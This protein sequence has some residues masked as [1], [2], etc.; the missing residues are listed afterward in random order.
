MGAF[1]F[2]KTATSEGDEVPVEIGKHGVRTSKLLRNQHHAVATLSHK[3]HLVAVAKLAL[4]FRTKNIVSL[5]PT[6]MLNGMN[7]AGTITPKQNPYGSKVEI[8]KAD[9]K[10]LLFRAY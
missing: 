5:K 2:R 3:N 7:G 1:I 4:R 9:E 10:L 6:R 8:I